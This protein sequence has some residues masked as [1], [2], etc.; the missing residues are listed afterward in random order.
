LTREHVRLAELAALR[1]R[2]QL[3]IRNA[4]PQEERQPRCEREVVQRVALSRRETRG[5]ALDAEQKLRRDEQAFEREPDACI[6]ALV[7]HCIG[8]GFSVVAT[9]AIE[10]NERSDLVAR[11]EPA[12]RAACEGAEYL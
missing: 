3:L 1:E 9:V 5:L 10:R 8:R 7:V 4:A 11:D 12:E 2:E 6:E